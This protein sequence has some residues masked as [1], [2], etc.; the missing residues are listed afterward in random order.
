MAV[1]LVCSAVAGTV[2]RFLRV[3]CFRVSVALAAVAT[4]GMVNVLTLQTGRGAAGKLFSVLQVSLPALALFV[5]CAWLAREVVTL[6]ADE[7]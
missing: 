5:L 1:V 4:I 7:R 3:W 6:P 2:P